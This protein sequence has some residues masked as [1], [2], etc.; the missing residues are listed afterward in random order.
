M[1]PARLDDPADFLPCAFHVKWADTN[2]EREHARHLRRS[3]FCLEQ[4]LFAGDD[5][6]A[7]DAQAQIIVALSQVGGAADAVVGTVRIHE[8]APAVWWGSRLAVHAAFRNHGRIGATLIRLAVS[9]AHAQGCR[10]FFAHV[11]A[12]N[13]AMFERLHWT[14]LRP[15]I[16][17][18]RAHCRM[19]ADLAHY[20]PCPDPY[21]G[22]VTRS[23]RPAP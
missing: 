14:A 10:R 13:V 12:Q 22:Y 3:V 11:Q 9:S 21:R 17:H 6:D 2:W 18:G 15:E 8:S 7:V 19:E 20:P 23:V 4:G 5:R 1:H 16:L